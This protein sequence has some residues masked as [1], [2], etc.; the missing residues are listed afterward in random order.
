MLTNVSMGKKSANQRE[1]VIL[2][3]LL[4]GERYGLEIRDAVERRT[5]KEIPLGSLYVT[6]DRME[7]AGFVKSR[8]GESGGDRGGNRRR[9]FSISARG[10]KAFKEA[11]QAIGLPA[12]GAI[13]H[14]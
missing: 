5:G 1:V 9:Y 12:G 11:A 8:M 7:A 4:H 10:L 2:G 6:L 13:A 14:A 3:T